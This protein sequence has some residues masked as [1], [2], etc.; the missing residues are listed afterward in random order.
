MEMIKYSTQMFK[1]LKKKLHVPNNT[2]EIQMI[3]ILE[4]SSDWPST[5]DCDFSVFMKLLSNFT[6][7]V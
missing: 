4:I 5:I 3:I 1:G 6:S 2:I 7:K